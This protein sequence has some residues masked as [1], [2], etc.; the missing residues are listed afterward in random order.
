MEGDDGAFEYATG[1]NDVHPACLWLLRVYQASNIT[2]TLV[3]FSGSDASVI[4]Y[5]GSLPVGAE[6]QPTK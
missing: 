3:E 5:P 2:F 4:L 6:F 1:I